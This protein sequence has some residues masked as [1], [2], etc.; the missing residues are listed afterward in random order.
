M[1]F[2]ESKDIPSELIPQPRPFLDL[3]SYRRRVRWTQGSLTASNNRA[4]I[5]LPNEDACSLNGRLR[6][7]ATVTSTGGTNEAPEYLGHSF[8]DRMRVEIG[9]SKIIDLDHFNS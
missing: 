6:F 5:V 2:A 3:Q 9:G 8:L 7:R 4:E 1:S